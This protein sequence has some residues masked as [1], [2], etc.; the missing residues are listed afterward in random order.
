MPAIVTVAESISQADGR[1]TIPWALEDPDQY[2]WHGKASSMFLVLPYVY[3]NSLGI[4]KNA[5]TAYQHYLHLALFSWG[6]SSLAHRGQGSISIILIDV[7][8]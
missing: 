6:E 7:N 8:V 2:H 3:L 5:Y 1:H 4:T